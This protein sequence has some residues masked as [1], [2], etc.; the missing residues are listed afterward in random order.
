MKLSELLGARNWQAD[1]RRL[2]A[3]Y[4]RQHDYRNWVLGLKIVGV[5]DRFGRK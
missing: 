4:K 5:L 1:R 2:D 3:G